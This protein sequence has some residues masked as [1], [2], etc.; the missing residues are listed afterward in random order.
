M[1][2]L[3]ALRPLP[4][5]IVVLLLTACDGAGGEPTIQLTIPTAIAPI[6]ATDPPAIVAVSPT[7][8]LPV[9]PTFE[10]VV[11]PTPVPVVDSATAV[12]SPELSYRV[13]F[14][15]SDDTLNVR[16][17]PGVQNGIVGVLAPDAAGVQILGAGQLVSG[18]RWVPIAADGLNGWV[19]GRFLT[20]DMASETFCQDEAGRDVLMDLETAVANQDGALLAQL[21]HSERGLRIRQSWWNPEI[22]ISQTD[23]RQIFASAASY[24]WGVQ[25]GSGNPIVGSF[26]QE[27]LPMLQKDLLAAAETGCD[28]IIHGGTAGYVR[29]PDGYGAVHIYSLHRPGTDEFA[30]MN[31]GT[32]VVGIEQWQGAFYISF[33]VHFQWEI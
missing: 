29:L 33:L 20:G 30:G 18:S 13:A 23:A 5:L 14:V 24:D 2:K 19:N 25:D 22:E 28:E 16:S 32:W 9:P 8:T 7:A 27:I 6:N 17:G 3:C 15:E 10:P 1:R 4:M 21:I 26:S 12:P 31:W 11:D